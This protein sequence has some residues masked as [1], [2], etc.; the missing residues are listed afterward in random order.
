M[1]SS[2]YLQEVGTKPG[3]PCPRGISEPV[4][5]TLELHY[6][7]I[8]HVEDLAYLCCRLSVYFPFTFTGISLKERGLH[9]ALR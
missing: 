4:N 2:S 6:L 3:A 5:G 1:L 9:V 7:G 8:R